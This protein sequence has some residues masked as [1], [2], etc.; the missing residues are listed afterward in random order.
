MCHHYWHFHAFNSC[1]FAAGSFVSTISCAQQH[2]RLLLMMVRVFAASVLL[3]FACPCVASSALRQL[4]CEDAQCSINCQPATFPLNACTKGEDGSSSMILTCD[5]TGE[6]SIRWSDNDQCSGSRNRSSDDVGH[7]HAASTG[8]SYINT[9]VAM[10]DGLRYSS[11]PMLH[12][13]PLEVARVEMPAVQ[14]LQC[15]DAHCVSNCNQSTFTLNTCTPGADGSSFMF[16]TC[17]ATGETNIHWSDN[18]QCS[19]NEGN[20]QIFS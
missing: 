10:H 12:R 6:T 15:E 20:G 2:Y 4:Q 5:A 13:A 17:D 18:N 9:C 7:C 8:G 14:Q 1:C 11:N 19:E 3:V 16:L